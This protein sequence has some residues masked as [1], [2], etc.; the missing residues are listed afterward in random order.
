LPP[1]PA[2]LASHL[3]MVMLVIKARQVEDTVQRKDFYLGCYV[4]PQAF[5]I[6][7]RYLSRNGEIASYVF[8]LR[9]RQ[10]R[11]WKR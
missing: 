3:T 10:R 4:V 5:S 1:Q 6:L 9:M 2:F 8:D 11:G 7:S